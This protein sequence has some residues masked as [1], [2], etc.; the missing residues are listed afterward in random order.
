MV[1]H[2]SIALHYGSINS[3]NSE[4][5]YMHM[6]SGFLETGEPVLEN[7]SLRIIIQSSHKSAASHLWSV[8]AP[9]PRVT[10]AVD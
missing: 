4:Q 1:K 7:L 8:A 3:T 2:R 5:D 10:H 9:V 6:L